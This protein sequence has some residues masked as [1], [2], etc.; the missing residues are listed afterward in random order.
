MEEKEIEV[1]G[2]CLKVAIEVSKGYIEDNNLK[3][4]LDDTIDLSEVVREVDEKN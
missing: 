3:V 1:N 2:K 4:L